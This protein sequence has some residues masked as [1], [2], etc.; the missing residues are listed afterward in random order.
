[1]PVSAEYEL[2]VT[3]Y[4]YRVSYFGRWVVT[5]SLLDSDIYG[6]CPAV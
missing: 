6:P 5:Y 1:M 3:L 4:I 2:D